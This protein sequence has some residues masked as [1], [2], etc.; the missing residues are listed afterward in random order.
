MSRDI[1]KPGAAFRSS[2][3]KNDIFLFAFPCSIIKGD[4]LYRRF[5]RVGGFIE[6]EWYRFQHDAHHLQRAAEFDLVG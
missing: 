4:S 5:N 6:P 1:I 3:V 2:Y